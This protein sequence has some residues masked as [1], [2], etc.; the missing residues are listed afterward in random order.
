MEDRRAAMVSLARA[1]KRCAHA[2]RWANSLWRS[3]DFS[4]S[5]LFCTSAFQTCLN[6]SQV[7][8]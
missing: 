2:A 3:L 5:Q 4:A 6:H 1:S 8:G 7:P